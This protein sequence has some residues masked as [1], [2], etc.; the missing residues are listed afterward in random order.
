[1]SSLARDSTL[2]ASAGGEV[3]AVAVCSFPSL[4]SSPLSARPLFAAKLVLG[5][6]RRRSLCL[7]SLQPDHDDEAKSTFASAGAPLSAA[8][9]CY[10][11]MEVPLP[12]FLFSPCQQHCLLHGDSTLRR[13]SL[14]A[15]LQAATDESKS[16]CRRRVR[17]TALPPLHQPR[18]ERAKFRKH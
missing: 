5:D 18:P 8:V 14:T 12:S 3:A 15:P 4:P 1:M 17:L 11:P 10:C 9:Q 16:S 2:R 7:L 13:P 6:R